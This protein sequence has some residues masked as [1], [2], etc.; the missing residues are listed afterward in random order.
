MGITFSGIADG[1]MFG[2][3]VLGSQ[4]LGVSIK[5]NRHRGPGAK[6]NNAVVQLGG[7]ADGNILESSLGKAGPINIFQETELS[8]RITAD[9]SLADFF[10]QGGRFSGTMAWPLKTARAAAD[11]EVTLWANS[12]GVSADVEVHSMGCGWVT[13]SYTEYP[14]LLFE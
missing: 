10:V 12:T 11:S 4:G 7:C 13:P 14:S 9:R 8:V 5:I 1:A 3:C 2:A 6:G